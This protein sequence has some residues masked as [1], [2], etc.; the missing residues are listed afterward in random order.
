MGQILNCEY[1]GYHPN[2]ADPLNASGET[3]CVA[4]KKGYRGSMK[5]SADTNGYIE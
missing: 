4:C 2:F 3:V 5:T 1:Y